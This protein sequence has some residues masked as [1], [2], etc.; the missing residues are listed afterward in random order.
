MK[1]DPIAKRHTGTGLLYAVHAGIVVV[2]TWLAT[3]PLPVAAQQTASG[4]EKL[5]Q[6]MKLHL[7]A[8]SERQLDEALK[9]AEEA[10]AEGLQPDDAVLAHQ[11]AASCLL[12][13]AQRTA[14]RLGRPRLFGPSWQTLR[15][16]ALDDLKKATEHVP[17]LAEAYRLMAEL[18]LLPDGDRQLGLKATEELL[19]LAD[20]PAARAEVYA[21][22]ARLR[23]N[24]E[25]QLEELRLA[26]EADPSNVQ[27]RQLYGRLLAENGKVEE[28]EHIFRDLA[29]D[30]PEQLANILALVELLLRQDDKLDDALEW[31]NRAVEL[32]KESPAALVAR[33]Q[34][35]LAKEDYDAALRDLDEAVKRDGRDVRTLLFRAQVHLLKENPKAALDDIQ[36]V[37][38]I[39]PGLV[40]A[41]RMRAQAYAYQKNYTDAIQDMELLIQ[42]DPNNAEYKLQLAYYCMADDR[43]RKAIRILT[44]IIEKDD[45]NWQALRARGDALLSIGKHAEAIQDY[46][47]ALQLKPDDSGLLNNLAWVLATSP[48]DSLRDGKRALELALK[49][50]ELTDYK[51]AHI[52]STLASAYAELG[53][54][55]NAIKWSTKAVELG[56]NDEQKEQLKKELETYRQGKP[57]REKQE[58][59][60]KPDIPKK[61]LLET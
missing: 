12:Q 57:F 37:L 14:S 17:D 32:D 26:V 25:Q 39:Q 55:E 41:I 19:R 22:R 23:D 8:R 56:E 43:P 6:A 1:V 38:K 36:T 60:E 34:V 20:E 40:L 42:H 53:D 2:A 7:E 28:A 51:E 5:Q 24:P 50:C 9:L 31:A 46:N 4:W 27:I 11:L 52:L 44:E 15:D 59:K 3:A 58:T 45:T 47:R 61:N 54:F 30:D 35:Y 21:L 29:R 18:C 33:A 49:A 48:E 10:L 16:R 13:R